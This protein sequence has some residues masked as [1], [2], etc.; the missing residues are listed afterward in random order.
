M[1][2]PV[3]VI[4]SMF[5][6]PENMQKRLRLTIEGASG[7]RNPN[8]LEPRPQG[9]TL[10]GKSP[11]KMGNLRFCNSAPDGVKIFSPLRKR[12]LQMSPLVKRVHH[13]KMGRK[14]SISLSGLVIGKRSVKIPLPIMPPR[15]TRLNPHLVH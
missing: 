6:K 10:E 9:K 12:R 8:V 14:P 15:M 4:L 3:L 13:W 2:N 7:I 5:T 1:M 11:R